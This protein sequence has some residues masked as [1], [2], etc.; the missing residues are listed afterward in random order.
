[1]KREKLIKKLQQIGVEVHEDKVRKSDIV[2]FLAKA[3]APA[4]ENSEEDEDQDDIDNI[5]DLLDKLQIPADGLGVLESYAEMWSKMHSKSGATGFIDLD[6]EEGKRMLDD[7]V[8][9]VNEY[10]LPAAE[11]LLAELDARKS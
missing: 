7:F 5:G 10:A 3:D 8:S 6:L 2:A 4:L 9:D 11:D 1:M